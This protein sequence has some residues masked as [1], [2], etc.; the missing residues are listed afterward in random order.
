MA[1]AILLTY[2][3]IGC[4]IM[5]HSRLYATSLSCDAKIERGLTRIL[6]VK[7]G[8]IYR[9]NTITQFKSLSCGLSALNSKNV[10]T[11]RH[12]NTY[13]PAKG[14]TSPSCLYLGK[15]LSV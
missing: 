14:G 10:P 15:A 13:A 5:F 6:P 1:T 11:N 9:Y 2:M 8:R 4:V 12:P 7:P 3:E